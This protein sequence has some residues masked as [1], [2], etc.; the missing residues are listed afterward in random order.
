VSKYLTR[1]LIDVSINKA[2]V[3]LN[4]SISNHILVPVLQLFFVNFQTEPT[5]KTTNMTGAHLKQPQT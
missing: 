1:F 5:L 4:R 3:I 2:D